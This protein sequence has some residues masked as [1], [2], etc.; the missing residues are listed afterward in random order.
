MSTV[1]RYN[2]TVI[3]VF[4]YKMAAFLDKSELDVRLLVIAR[5]PQITHLNGC[6]VSVHL[7]IYL[8]IC[9]FVCLFF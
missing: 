1:Q 7:F 2:I 4:S 5:V 8:F 3:I 9:L 6:Q